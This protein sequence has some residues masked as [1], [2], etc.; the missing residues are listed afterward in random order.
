[1]MT[2][3]VSGSLINLSSN[4]VEL[5]GRLII[6]QFQKIFFQIDFRIGYKTLSLCGSKKDP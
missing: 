3:N 1:M 5:V 4:D 6:D 2:S